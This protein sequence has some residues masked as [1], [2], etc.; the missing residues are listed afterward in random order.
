MGNNAGGWRTTDGDYGDLD[1]G[2]IAPFQGFF[3]QNA[4]A[5]PVFTFSEGAETTGGNFYG[6]Q[7]EN[8]EHV[9]RFEINGEGLF[10]SVWITLSNNGSFDRTI[11]DA[12]ELIPFNENY[13]LFGSSK[14]DTMFDIAHFPANP[15]TQIPIE[16][17]TTLP[18]R[19]TIK[20]TDVTLSPGAEIVLVDTKTN[21]SITV[22][23]DFEYTFEWN[24]SIIEANKQVQQGNV[25]CG[26]VEQVRQQFVPTAA[27]KN[28][29]S[30]SRFY[31][32]FTTDSH[33]TEN[34]NLPDSFLLKQNFPNPFNPTTQITYELPQQSDVTLQI[35]DLT[36]RQVATLVNNESVS[37]GTH[38]V[39]FDATNLSSGMYIYRLQA[40]SVVLSRKLTL[41]K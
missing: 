15:V 13:V 1:G 6:K 24:E 7:E 29:N 40:G 20:A 16:I 18:G 14:G 28:K 41:I 38:T 3:I 25:A 19:Y 22:D 31:L 4:G 26:T 17:E 35:F 21:V 34:P 33:F 2:I 11:S 8:A 37:A 5:N 32:K 23:K 9:L 30:E 39:N 12:L 27:Q 36:G 10:N